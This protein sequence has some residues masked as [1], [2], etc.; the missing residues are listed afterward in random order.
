MNVGRFEGATG[1]GNARG[2][3]SWTVH[4]EG[5]VCFGG[6]LRDTLQIHVLFLLVEELHALLARL[7]LKFTFQSRVV[8]V[9]NVV[10]CTPREMLGDL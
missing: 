6:A 5:Q 4:T 9:L 10:V 3:L 1:N 8:M 2:H 7:L